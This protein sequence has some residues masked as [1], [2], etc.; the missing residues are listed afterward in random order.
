MPMGAFFSTQTF[1]FFDR[2]MNFAQLLLALGLNGLESDGLRRL[3][4]IFVGNWL[5]LVDRL[6]D[7]SLLFG[8]PMCAL[9]S[10]PT[11]KPGLNRLGS[12][13]QHILRA[14][15]L[16]CLAK[17][18]AEPHRLLVLSG[19]PA[20]SL[21]RE[22]SANDYWLDAGALQRFLRGTEK[23]GPALA[24]PRCGSRTDGLSRSRK[25][26]FDLL[27]CVRVR[28]KKALH[29]VCRAVA[30]MPRRDELRNRIQVVA[31]RDQSRLIGT[32]AARLGV[33][34]IRHEGIAQ[35]FAPHGFLDFAAL[36]HVVFNRLGRAAVADL[37][38]AHHVRLAQVT[39]IAGPDPRL[40]N[41]RTLKWCPRA[42]QL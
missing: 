22:K 6:H 21:A 41:T 3:G 17:R 31:H 40:V 2:L 36:G 18:H 38:L 37:A 28:A 23:R 42:A 27:H 30:F 25:H 39:Q 5:P 13:D 14:I 34:D 32:I 15:A 12:S 1:S 4:L 19:D 16:Q 7:F 26:G 9:D 29:D 10:L 33:P 11:P 8:A 20:G 24:S 35:A